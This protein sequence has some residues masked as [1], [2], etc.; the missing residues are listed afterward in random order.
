MEKNLNQKVVLSALYAG[1]LMASHVMAAECGQAKLVEAGSTNVSVS[2]NTCTDNSQ[3]SLG[4]VLELSSG[5][6]MWL[7]FNPSARGE[8]FQL[9]CQNK[10]SGAVKVNVTSTTDP[11][12]KPEGIK[13][14]E[15]WKN[16]KLSCE[17]N[18]GEKNSFFCALAKA[19]VDTSDA[20]SKM[21]MTTSVKMRGVLPIPAVTVSA[22]DIIASI[23]PE[24]EL[25]KTLYNVTDQVEMSWTVSSGKIQD[26]NVSNPNSDLVSCMGDAAKQTNLNQDISIKYSF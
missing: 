19:K 24:I 26:L 3:I 15:K 6:R 7:K 2:K 1:L 16:N 20:A 9:I 5:S 22:D 17:S 8:T 18:S 14:C 13:S 10:S 21:A 4:S 11:W 25:C 12:V 23:K